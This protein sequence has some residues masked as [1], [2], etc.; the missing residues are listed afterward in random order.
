MPYF[1]TYAKS[2]THTWRIYRGTWN[3]VVYE[4]SSRKRVKMS[5]LLVGSLAA[6]AVGGPRLYLPEPR[7]LLQTVG[8]Q[9]EHL[10]APSH[11]HRL[12]L[13]EEL[14][15]RVVTLFPLLGGGGGG[16]HTILSSD[17]SC[18]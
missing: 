4:N 5:S 9:R 11:L 1:R 8:T 16:C 6:T 2:M 10:L 18:L 15:H 12:D 17:I 14:R 13:L 7:S 3:I